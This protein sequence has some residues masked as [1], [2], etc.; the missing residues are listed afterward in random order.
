MTIEIIAFTDPVCTWCWGAEPVLRAVQTRY[1]DQVHVSYVMGGLVRDIRQ[2]MDVGNAIG[3]DPASSNRNIVAHWLDASQRH[4]MPVKQAGFKLFTDNHPSTYP[5]NEAY[6]AARQQGEDLA[7]A[8]LRRLRE[9]SAAEARQTNRIEV[10]AE[11]AAE[12][13]LDVGTFLTAMRDGSAATAF[14][15]DLA[16]TAAHGVRGFPAFI[17]K[18]QAEKGIMLPGYQTYGTFREVISL[19]SQGTAVE[20]TLPKDAG[21]VFEL[22][23]RWGSVSDVEITTALDLNDEEWGRLEPQVTADPGVATV[24]AG[25]GRFFR[26]VAPVAGTCDPATAVCPV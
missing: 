12:A 19:V 22:I 20:T 24:P 2:F 5:L 18:G 23:R 9:A 1:G 21:S 11:L 25:N 26:S 4:G 14:Q 15:Q 10:L 17:V 3:G 13:G 16:I 8:F 7:N 6:L